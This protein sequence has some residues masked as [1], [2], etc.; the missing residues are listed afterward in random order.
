LEFRTVPV[1]FFS[2]VVTMLTVA[3]EIDMSTTPRLREYLTTVPDRDTVLDLSGVT[4]LGA[5][6]LTVLLELHHRLARADAQLVLAAL[7]PGTLRA[8][9][10]TGLDTTLPATPTVTHAVALITTEVTA[11]PAPH[12]RSRH[13]RPL[14]TPWLDRHPTHRRRPWPGRHPRHQAPD[15]PVTPT[16]RTVNRVQ[17]VPGEH[18][19]L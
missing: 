5:A 10:A 11:R 7:S 13:L 3:G 15:G 18:P 14:S 16:Q 19:D 9:A 8:L 17:E 1:E 4:L 6:G 12:S 2:R